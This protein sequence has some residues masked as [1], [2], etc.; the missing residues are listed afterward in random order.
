[1]IIVGIDNGTSGSIG[2]LGKD[3]S[4]AQMHLVPSFAEQDVTQKKQNIT[5]LDFDKFCD[6]L[7]ELVE[8]DPNVQIFLE[9][10]LKNPKLF[11]STIS[12]VRCLEAQL[13]AFKLLALPYQVIDSKHWQKVFFPVGTTSKDTKKLSKEVGCRLFPHL[14]YKIEAHGDADGLLIARYGQKQFNRIS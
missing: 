9:R 12:A 13:I 4:L 1:M 7:L 2:V 5:R 11:N 3:N 10:P 14:K 6:F 8:D